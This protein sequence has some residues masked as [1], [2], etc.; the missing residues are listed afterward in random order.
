[1]SNILNKYYTIH[2]KIKVDPFVLNC[3][4][5]LNHKP[6]FKTLLRVSSTKNNKYDFLKEKYQSKATNT[7][8]VDLANLSNV[9]DKIYYKKFFSKI[10]GMKNIASIKNIDISQL[11]E[12]QKNNDKDKDNKKPIIISRNK[13]D[14]K[15]KI[16]D[17]KEKNVFKTFEYFQKKNHIKLRRVQSAKN[18]K[19][20]TSIE[21]KIV[22]SKV[23]SLVKDLLSKDINFKY[24]NKEIHSRNSFP[25]NKEMNPK[26]YIEYNLKN[27]PNNPKLFKS[28]QLQMKYLFV[29]N[30]RKHLIEGVNDYDQNIKKYK[31]INPKEMFDKKVNEKKLFQKKL[32]KVFLNIKPMEFKNLS[33]KDKNNTFKYSYEKDKF[34]KNYINVYMGKSVD[35]ELSRNKYIKRN[36]Y[37]NFMDS[38]KF[39]KMMSLDDKIKLAQSNSKK[40]LKFVKKD[41]M[42]S[43]Q[44]KYIL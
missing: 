34:N 9:L 10:N 37:F 17:I 24:S 41:S 11:V 38:D 28:F 32:K 22:K 25:L 1:M 3:K 35:K 23:N 19:N 26:K 29:G 43:F 31:E 16:K 39:K 30:N 20:N 13:K 36:K 8:K 12:N 40:L 44:K 14:I 5:F 18:V 7:P 21:Q 4:R 42:K 27:D 33:S 15:E 6:N 2:K